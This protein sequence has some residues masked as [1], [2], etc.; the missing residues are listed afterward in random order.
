MELNSGTFGFHHIAIRARDFDRSLQFYTRGLGCDRVYGWGEGK[1]QVALL[2][3]GNGCLVEL[4]GNSVEP[5]EVDPS[6][7]IMHFALRVDDVDAAF[8][9]A[10]SAG[11]TEYI[12]PKAVNLRGDYELQFRNAL[13]RGP[14]GEIIEFLKIDRV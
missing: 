3:F 2:D 1:G 8:E 9:N 12:R 11:G 13:V 6:D 10:L 4:F 7:V 5:R 14:S